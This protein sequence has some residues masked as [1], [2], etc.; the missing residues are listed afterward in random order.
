[1]R[2][3]LPALLAVAM[4]ATGRGDRAQGTWIL[5]IQGD[6]TSLKIAAAAHKAFAYRAPRGVDS[7]Y[8]VQLI[9]S[10]GKVLATVPLDLSKFCMDS[11]HEGDPAHLRGDVV[12]SHRVTCT[13]KVP[14]RADVAEIRIERAGDAD[15]PKRLGASDVKSVRELLAAHARKQAK[16]KSQ[17]RER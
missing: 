4:A 14:A 2:C 13:V 17:R 1:M 12:R 8:R 6:A 9:D 16:V 10:A 15:R 7:D 5:Q 11:T 3:M